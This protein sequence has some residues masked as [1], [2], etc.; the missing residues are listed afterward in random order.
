M[1]G[2]FVFPAFTAADVVVDCFC[3]YADSAATTDAEASDLP[4]RD[5]F[6]AERATDAETVC[7]L[8]HREQLG[9]G[10]TNVS[11]SWPISSA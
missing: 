4:R 5:Q 3:A 8:G 7:N 2:T 11:A 1:G 10:A 9:H 6:M